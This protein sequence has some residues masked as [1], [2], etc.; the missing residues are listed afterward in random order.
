[1]L[2]RYCALVLMGIPFFSNLAKADFLPPNDLHLEDGIIRSSDITESEFNAIIDEVIEIYEPIIKGAHRGRLKVNRLWS[3]PT[4]N[5][6]ATQIFGSWEINMYGGL[7]RRP[8]ITPDGFAMVVCHELGHHLA[9]YPFSGAWAADEG[10][11]DYFA[12][13]T[14]GR[15]LWKDQSERN[16]EARSQIDEFPKRACD[17]QW[18]DS[19]EQNLCYR[20]MLAARSTAELLSSQERKAIGWDTPDPAVV[21]STY[22]GHPRGQCRLDTYMAGAL[23]GLQFDS[24]LIPGKELGW[25]RNSAEAEKLSARYTCTQ[26]AK[27]DVGT[28]PRCW[29]KPLL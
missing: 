16:A 11:S 12:T 21:K 9:G 20:L 13:H 14:C 22:H 17:A 4:V 18:T 29:F 19:S 27:F 5:A 26:Y 23:C 15:L 1:M 3:N 10:Q 6:S 25:S 2:K 7:A 8:E 28:R 24:N